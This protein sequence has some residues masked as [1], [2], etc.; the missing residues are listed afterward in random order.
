MKIDPNNKKNIN[1][2]SF[3]VQLYNLLL[4]GNK[5]TTING[6][7]LEAHFVLKNTL[8]NIINFILGSNEST[9]T[10]IFAGGKIFENLFLLF[11]QT[12]ELFNIVYSEILFKGTGDLFQEINCVTK[13]GAYTMDSSYSVDDG[14]LPY[15]GTN[16]DQL[17]FFAANDRPSGTRFMFMLIHGK[18][19]EINTKAVG[20]YYS[21]NNLVLVKRKEN[22]NICEPIRGGQTKRGKM[23][24]RKTKKIIN[25]KNMRRFTNKHKR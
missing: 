4:K 15:K 12:K 24:Y 20:G 23:K 5:S 8:L 18:E 1:L 10:Q 21:E 25:K 17:R 9:R 19:N 22:K 11:S 3:D 6:S 16:G 2:L 13:Y 7:D 14:I